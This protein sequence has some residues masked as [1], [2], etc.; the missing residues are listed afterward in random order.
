MLSI[1]GWIIGW[2]KCNL[3]LD[4]KAVSRSKQNSRTTNK[5]LFVDQG[6]VFYLLGL[7]PE[8]LMV[9]AKPD[10]SV[11][12]IRITKQHIH[13]LVHPDCQA[14]N[15]YTTKLPEPPQLLELYSHYSHYSH[16]STF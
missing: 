8:I 3:L 10:P 12:L 9:D 16:Y 7:T 11:G 2:S 15:H 1:R 14:G 4:P 13:L 5:L 6:L